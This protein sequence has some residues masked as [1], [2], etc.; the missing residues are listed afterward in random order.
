MIRKS[1][2]ILMLMT[3]ILPFLFIAVLLFTI[4]PV[5]V[6]ADLKLWISSFQ[7]QSYYEQMGELY[8][9][10]TGKELNLIVEAYGFREM[11]DKLGAVMQTGQGVP[12][13]V[14]LDETFFGVFLNGPSPFPTSLRKSENPN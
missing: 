1:K 9:R 2:D 4:H 6:H 13:L 3:Q 10:K 11:P 14:Q 7:D 12:D 5:K 8:N